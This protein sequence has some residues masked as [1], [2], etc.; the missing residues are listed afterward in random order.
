[1]VESGVDFWE[2]IDFRYGKM[3]LNFEVY[4]WVH[5]QYVESFSV[6]RMVGGI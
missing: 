3:D 6:V 4:Y 5:H 2:N 1:M